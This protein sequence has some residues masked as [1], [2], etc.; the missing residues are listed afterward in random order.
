[1]GIEPRLTPVPLVAHS[2]GPRVIGPA[3][4]MRHAGLRHLT[5]RVETARQ[6]RTDQERGQRGPTLFYNLDFEA[7]T[8]PF[9][10]HDLLDAIHQ[11]APLCGREEADDIKL[12]PK[13]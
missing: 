13:P 11:P 7:N 5:V 9:L 6:V 1:M 4:G 2:A 12:W 3:P 8:F 10:L